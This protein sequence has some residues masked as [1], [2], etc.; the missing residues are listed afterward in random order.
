MSEGD[1][2]FW[3]FSLR[4]YAREGVPALCLQLQD[5]QGVDVN[6]LFFMFFLASRG[7]RLTATDVRRINES[8]ADWRNRAVKPLRALRRDLK[9]GIAGMDAQ[10]VESFRSDIKR[11]ELHAERIQQEMLERAFPAAAQGTPDGAADA[12]AANVAAYGSVIENG[13]TGLPA[14]T[15]Q[16]L[17]ASFDRELA[18][19]HRA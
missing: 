10:T 7:R 6:L 14:D 19:T 1:S 11:C 17:L 9:T 16:A 8:T 3:R 13:T 4:F 12:A 18:E 5:A 2:A 15:V